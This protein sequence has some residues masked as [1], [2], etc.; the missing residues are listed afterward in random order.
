MPRGKAETEEVYS[1]SLGASYSNDAPGGFL[2]SRTT[3][4][5]RRDAG[6]ARL[7]VNQYLPARSTQA[8]PRCVVEK[9]I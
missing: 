9:C 7:R 2:C 6:A 4:A 3:S 5:A 1:V 8:A